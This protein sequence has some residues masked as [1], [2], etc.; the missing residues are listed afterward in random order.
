[1][2]VK[3]PLVETTS[4]LGRMI[5]DLDSDSSR[6]RPNLLEQDKNNKHSK[7]S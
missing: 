3:N 5:R 1:M 7:L 6:K 4:S 2:V